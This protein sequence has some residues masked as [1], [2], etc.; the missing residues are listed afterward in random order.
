MIFFSWT[1]VVENTII[2]FFLLQRMNVKVGSHATILIEEMAQC[3]E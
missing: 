3:D 1:R 2:F